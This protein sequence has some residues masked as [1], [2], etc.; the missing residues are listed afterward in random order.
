MSQISMGNT[1]SSAHT[2]N[3]PQP[4]DSPVN[5]EAHFTD[6]TFVVPLDSDRL[7]LRP[8]TELQ[9]TEVPQH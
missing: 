7:Q 4:W 2:A 6:R 1:S 3:I 9:I 8:L 5:V